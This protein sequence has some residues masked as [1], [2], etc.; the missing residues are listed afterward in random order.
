MII[1]VT[2]IPGSGKSTVA[3]LLSEPFGHI[4]DMD[5]LGRTATLMSGKEIEAVLGERFFDDAGNLIPHKLGQFIFVEHPEK[6]PAFNAVVHPK[7]KELV[8]QEI[9][10][11]RGDKLV[12]VD[13]ALLIELGL[14]ELCDKV[15][16]VVTPIELA[17]ERFIKR[18]GYAED[19]FWNIL[20]YQL[21]QEDKAQ[22]S[23]ILI[24]N[25]SPLSHLK[26]EVAR[27]KKEL[28]KSTIN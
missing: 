12:V 13:G 28:F 26:K 10:R 3:K 2:G 1:G 24:R 23:D 15:I 11:H 9:E 27:V 4:V 7:L 22:R 19:A 25:D 8:T 21:S 14:N 16:A 17:V 5:H 20:K 6:M 18:T